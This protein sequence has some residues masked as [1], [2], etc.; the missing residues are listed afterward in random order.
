[1]KSWYA[2][3]SEIS[4][5]YFSSG[6]WVEIDRRCL[7]EI[8]STQHQAVIPCIKTSLIRP[9][10]ICGFATHLFVDFPQ[11][12]YGLK[13]H[14]PFNQSLTAELGAM[15]DAEWNSTQ[16]HCLRGAIAFDVFCT[17]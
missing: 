11:Y 9:L 13:H 17:P 16:H 10:Q 1:M 6:C 2:R 14:N 3:Q 8:I 12:L 7:F 15:L 5:S 4:E